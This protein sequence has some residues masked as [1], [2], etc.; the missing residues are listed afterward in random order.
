MMA[1][2]PGIPPARQ[3]KKMK[4]D[5]H[6]DYHMIKVVMTDGTEYM[7]RRPGAP[8]AK[9]STSTSTPS[10]TRHGPAASRTCSTA[11][12]ACRSSRSA[13]KASACKNSGVTGHVQNPLVLPAG[14]FVSGLW[15]YEA[16]AGQG[17]GEQ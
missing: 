16:P 2:A 1:R 14:F 13:S 6:P 7:T 9:R 3:D 10:R 15:E 5:I 11:A 12:V 4:A 17:A 8:R